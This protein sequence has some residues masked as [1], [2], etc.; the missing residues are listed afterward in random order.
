MAKEPAYGIRDHVDV[1]DGQAMSGVSEN[2]PL[3]TADFFD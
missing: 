3:S 2:L 1:G